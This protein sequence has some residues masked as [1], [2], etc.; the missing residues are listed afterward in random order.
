MS[1][2]KRTVMSGIVLA[3]IVSM[4]LLDIAP[5]THSSVGLPEYNS[6]WVSINKGQTIRLTHNLGTTNVSIEMWGKDSGG[7]IHQRNYGGNQL[8]HQEYSDLGFNSPPA[9]DSKWTPIGKGDTKL[10]H[11]LNTTDVF[12]YMIGKDSDGFVHQKDYG[13]WSYP[14]NVWYG[15]YWYHLDENSITVHRHGGD[16]DWVQVR[17]MIWKIPPTGLQYTSQ[18]GAYWDNLTTSTIDVYRAQNDTDWEQVN[19]RIWKIQSSQGVGGLYVRVDK[20]SL[21]APYI[22]LVSTIILAV[23]ITGAYIKYKKKQ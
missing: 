2:S 17:V 12:V 6:G 21:L 22:A 18:V 3:G 10:Y 5:M 8:K 9:W 20:F 11:N 14:V 7:Y 13:G 4:V 19:V 16:G 15:A 1:E 23:S